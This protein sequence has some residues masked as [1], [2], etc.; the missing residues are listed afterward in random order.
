MFEILPDRV[1]LNSRFFSYDISIDNTHC[2]ATF[3]KLQV[4]LISE[5]RNVISKY[6][7]EKFGLK[8]SLKFERELFIT[9]YFHPMYYKHKPLDSIV[10]T[11]SI[12]IYRKV[13]S[14]PCLDSK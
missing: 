11:Q 1:T 14:H 9:Y 13:R 3:K 10:L 7:P 12:D 4:I 6:F 5:K 8:L 2:T